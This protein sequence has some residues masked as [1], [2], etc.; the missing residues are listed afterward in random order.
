MA[1][2]DEIFNEFARAFVG[3]IVTDKEV[4][5]PEMLSRDEL[6]GSLDSLKL[7]DQYL[8]HLHES[9]QV[10]DEAAWHTTVLWAGAYVGEVI[11]NAVDPGLFHWEDYNEYVP[12]YP[13]LRGIIPE[14]TVSTCAFLVA[15]DDSMSMPM[16]KVARCIEEGPENNVHFFARCDI[17][18]VK[19][20]TA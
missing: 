11:R 1:E 8:E 16:N 9:R 14:R 20:P 17:N 15:P 18:K 6:D 19:K 2:L 5:F 3:T 12:K 10:I 4:A 7:V 13:K